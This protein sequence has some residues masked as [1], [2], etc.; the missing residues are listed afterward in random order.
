ML[1]R[2]RTLVLSVVLAGAG[3]AVAS[4]AATL[5]GHGPILQHQSA[6]GVPSVAARSTLTFDRMGAPVRSW[7]DARAKNDALLYVSDYSSDQVTVFSYPAG[8]QMGLLSGLGAPEGM[9]VDAKD[10]V[11]VARAGASEVSEFAHGGTTPIAT[12]ADP[13]YFPASCSV[14]PKT[15]DLAVANLE[16]SDHGLP[17]NVAIYS[18]S[19][20]SPTYISPP[21]FY[22]VYFVGYDKKAN[23][24]AD[25]TDAEVGANGAF[26][27]GELPH[28]ASQ[29]Q[30]IVLKGGTI[31]FPGNVQWDGRQMTVGDQD[32]A[33][34]YE[35]HKS[36]LVSRT[37][38]TGSSDV[39]QYFIDGSTV[40]GP[41]AGDADVEFYGFPGGGS[42]THELTGF[43]MPNGAVVSK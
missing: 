20:G 41:D 31:A 19:Q 16:A 35:I 10:N 2:T 17:G 22:T 37:P 18:G 23:L 26:E 29:M 14:N 43:T 3:I 40:I 7:M 28:G 11:Y 38:L 13:G 36:T 21:G 6:R 15:G 39:V 34:I 30:N 4:A 42:P 32:N 1:I 12:F 24:F 25:G 5:H 9:C 8:K 33:V 27:F